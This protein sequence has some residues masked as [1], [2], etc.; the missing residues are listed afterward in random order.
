[1][2]GFSLTLRPLLPVDETR[3]VSVA[4][5]MWTRGDF[6]VPHLN[7]HPYSDKPPLLFWLFQLGWWAFG[8]NEWWPRLVPALCSLANLF[9]VSVLARRLWPER[10]AIA[11]SVPFVLL[12]FLLWSVFTGMLMFDML[13]SL[14][15]LV[16]L[17][18]LYDAWTRGA[19]AWIQVGIA[20]GVGALAKGPVVLVV[21]LVVAVLAPWW[22]GRRPGWR[23]WLGLTGALIVAH[24]V[25]LSWA[26]P[27][28]HAGGEAYGNAILFSQTE[29]RMVHSFAHLR[30]WWWYLPLLPVL[31]Y[32]YSI[33]PP[34]WRS[35]ARLRPRATDSGTRFCLAWILPAL[36]V[37]SLISGKQPHYLLPLLPGF[38]LLVARLLDEPALTPRRRTMAPAMAVLLLLAGVLTAAPFLAGRLG[39][40]PWVGQISPAGGV[41]LVVAAAGCFLAFE[42]IFR[43]PAEAPALFTLLALAAVYAGCAGALRQYY[44]VRPM[45]RYLASV[46][47][48]GRPIGF[49]GIYHD[50]FHFLGRLERPFD[51]VPAGAEWYW[52][53]EHP[54]GKLVED[55]RDVPPG[56]TRTDFTQPYRTGFLAV[57]SR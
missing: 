6:L 5:E 4:W 48:Q 38:A 9:L 2:T 24:A 49:V 16:A 22:G 10:P 17:L 39:Q 36:V 21:P 40:A 25:A 50:Q 47:R 57:W 27:A 46:E 7:G 51:E 56:I 37:F 53:A 28:A 31:L 32:P 52:L 26:I 55:L 15:V 18:G 34:L 30:P 44:D 33:W 45:A 12:G 3:Y 35:T 14:C 54:T 43:R 1:M 42:R 23:W 20:I 11:R 19:R 8:V 29:E 13:V 41:F